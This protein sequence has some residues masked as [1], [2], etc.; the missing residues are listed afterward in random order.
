MKRGG[1][2]II[3]LRP[4]PAPTA[5]VVASMAL[6]LA[7]NTGSMDI[8]PRKEEQEISGFQTYGVKSVAIH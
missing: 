6:G 1:Q 8:S 4:A 3:T 2:T 5:P 7:V